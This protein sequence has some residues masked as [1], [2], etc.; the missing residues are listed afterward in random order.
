MKFINTFT[1]PV[2]EAYDEL[3]NI[4]IKLNYYSKKLDVLIGQP[5]RIGILSDYLINYKNNDE[6]LHPFFLTDYLDEINFEKI[7]HNIMIFTQPEDIIDKYNI[8]SGVKDVFKKKYNDTYKNYI[9]MNNGNA[10]AIVDI[11]NIKK[12]LAENSF[13]KS[14]I[15]SVKCYKHDVINTVIA[16]LQLYV[17]YLINMKEL[18]MYI[19]FENIFKENNYKPNAI[20]DKNAPE[21]YRNKLIKY[22]IDCIEFSIS[23]NII[24]TNNTNIDET[25][26][27]I[28]Q[29]ILTE[30]V[31]SV[32]TNITM[33]I[34]IFKFEL[35]NI[36][37]P[38][39]TFTQS[40]YDIITYIATKI[41]DNGKYKPDYKWNIDSILLNLQSIPPETHNDKNIFD[42]IYNILNASD[43][44][45]NYYLSLYEFPFDIDDIKFYKYHKTLITSNL[46]F[47]SNEINK[48]S[49]I[50][51]EPNIRN[52]FNAYTNT[53]SKD[54]TYTTN[55]LNFS[56]DI[57]LNYMYY[58][59]NTITYDGTKNVSTVKTENSLNGT[60][61]IN[62]IQLFNTHKNNIASIAIYINN[63]IETIKKSLNDIGK[64]FNTSTITDYATIQTSITNTHNIF[65]IIIDEINK[66]NNS[67]TAYEKELLEKICD[68]VKNINNLLPMSL[69]NKN[70]N[71]G[72]NHRNNLFI[73][74]SALSYINTNLLQYNINNDTYI[75][76]KLK[77]LN[78]Y[79]TPSSK[80]ITELIDIYKKINYVYTRADTNLLSIED[81]VDTNIFKIDNYNYISPTIKKPENS[82]WGY[83][84]F[85]SNNKIQKTILI[86]FIVFIKTKIPPLK[87]IEPPNI[88]PSPY[89]IID[90]SNSNN[91]IIITFAK[92]QI[93]ETKNMLSTLKTYCTINTSGII[94]LIPAVNIN[95]NIF[96][97]L[98]NNLIN[99]LANMQNIK[100][101][102]YKYIY[103]LFRNYIYTQHIKDTYI[104]LNDV[105]NI[106]I[107]IEKI[108]TGIYN[109]LI[110]F[111][112]NNATIKLQN[113]NKMTPAANK[114]IDELQT[115]DAN[116]IY[117][118]LNICAYLHNDYYNLIMTYIY[119][120]L[121]NN[122]YT[123]T[124]I[125]NIINENLLSNTH[126]ILYDTHYKNFYAKQMKV[127]PTTPPV[128]TSTTPPPA[129]TTPAPSTTPIANTM[130]SKLLTDITETT[131]PPLLTDYNDKLF[132]LYANS[133]IILKG[134]YTHINNIML[135]S[136]KKSLTKK[137]VLCARK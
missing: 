20:I 66:K 106:D 44:N 34:D 111:I 125:I 132:A 11:K 58:N 21:Y 131:M 89:V 129:P 104:V 18:Y 110:N 49:S 80:N 62:A 65:K 128:A 103:E 90:T 59:C 3:I 46:L 79:T 121:Y 6:I 77:I 115:F 86:D 83:P 39:F 56:Y 12:K 57:L 135:K 24:E 76:I 122:K 43:M 93:T 96:G 33:I 126:H 114:T 9:F 42:Y 4:I 48:N 70:I 7:I 107:D 75:N 30:L 100:I 130:K 8:S 136:K 116:K 17:S 99:K 119:T 41:G 78:Q 91:L 117:D 101:F 14:N 36:L 23:Y 81:V 38:Y 5:T 88:T 85:S 68:I 15:Y 97:N 60:I 10:K 109:V 31:T 105:L 28:N 47:N 53:P 124:S 52:M 82:Q 13:A 92:E 133:K 1:Q 94:N 127:A 63:H 118:I 112:T 22:I 54:I 26:Y 2:T 61:T 72:L 16:D 64:I 71:K 98:I 29:P 37:I 108:N 32:K 67:N 55:N 50:Y 74:G 73:A 120:F 25:E 19:L 113:L 45:N 87:A 40:N 95:D 134:G 102:I 137:K 123:Q 51:S 84:L 27:N 69:N 35:N